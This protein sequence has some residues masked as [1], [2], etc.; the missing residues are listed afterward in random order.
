[1]LGFKSFFATLLCMVLLLSPVFS[2]A[3][4][5]ESNVENACCSTSVEDEHDCCDMPVKDSKKEQNTSCPSSCSSFY[6]SNLSMGAFVAPEFSSL[7]QPLLLF[8]KKSS[9]VYTRFF[10]SQPL[11][12]IWQPPKIS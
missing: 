12:E 6:L 3:S 4:N 11:S 5:L 8:D 1:M 9:T 7:P 2:L 10:P